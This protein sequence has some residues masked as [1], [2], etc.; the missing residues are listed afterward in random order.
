MNKTF[1]LSFSISTG[2]APDLK[3]T[4]EILQKNWQALGADV[5]VKIF[6][7]GDLNQNIIR[8]RKYDALLFGEVVSRDFDLY[9][10]WHSSE[11]KDPG[12]NIAQYVNSKT[13]KILETLRKTTD[14]GERQNLYREFNTEISADTPAVF[15]YAPYFVY[16][17]PERVRN[18]S[19]GSIASPSERFG[20]VFEWYTETNNVWKI[21]TAK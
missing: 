8:P 13:D 21:F 20:N 19:I 3:A 7:T 4:A 9:P 14:L 1:N 12:L 6:E 17:A 2:D 10:F 11:R 18:I 15:L 16:V 5:S